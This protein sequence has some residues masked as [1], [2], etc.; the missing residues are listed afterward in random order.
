MPFSKLGLSD[1]IVKAITELGYASPTPIQTKAIPVILSG[2]NVLGAAQ[3]GT[4]KTASFVL[5][6]LQMFADAQKFAPSEYAPLSLHRPVNLPFR[7]RKISANTLNICHSPLW[8]CTEV[9]MPHL[10]RK[11]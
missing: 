8:R 3:T 5:P 9:S 10:K 11:N 2:K 6:L 1:P 7:L 4:G